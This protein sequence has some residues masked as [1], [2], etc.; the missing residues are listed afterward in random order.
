[1]LKYLTAIFLILSSTQMFASESLMMTDEFENL[2]E[3]EQE[4]RLFFENL[5][6]M[7]DEDREITIA[8]F[9]L[10]W[11]ETGTYK[12]KQSNSTILLPEGYNL[13]IGKEA[14]EGRKIMCGDLYDPN[15]EALICSDDLENVI[16][17]EYLP[18]GFVSLNDWED[19]DPKP[20]LKSIRKSTEQA[21][22]ERKKYGGEAI[23]VIG[24]IQKP[25]LDKHTNTVYWAIEAE[26]DEGIIVNSIALRLGRQGFEKFNWITPKA[27]YVPFG[28]HLD[29]MLQSHSFDPGYRYNDYSFGDKLASYGVASLVAAT[30]GGTIIKAGKFG[31]ILKILGGSIF[32]GIAALFYKFKNIFRRKED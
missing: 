6:Q 29:V 19:L 22:K 16:L 31:V 18:S 14:N 1:M 12:L 2:S 17:F 11:K 8:F 4:E 10:D 7:S 23:H 3:E 24:W 30:V 9:S 13:L 15:L 21:N 32:A 27:S 28:G 26:S 25:V 20:L 5:S